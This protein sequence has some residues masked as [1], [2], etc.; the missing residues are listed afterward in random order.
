M[1]QPGLLPEE[2]RALDARLVKLRRHLQTLMEQ[3]DPASPDYWTIKKTS[4]TI[5]RMRFEL[6]ENQGTAS[7]PSER[8]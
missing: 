1:T 5:D 6:Q 7:A 3:L 4:A 8:S 2:Y